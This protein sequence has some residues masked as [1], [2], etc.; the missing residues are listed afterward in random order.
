[1]VRVVG[2]MSGTSLDGVDAAILDTDGV[3]VAATGDTAYRP[4][5][6]KERAVLRTALGTWPGDPLAEA[7]A[8]VVEAAHLEVLDGLPAVDLVGFHGQTLS[9]DPAGARTH[10]AGDG[11]RLARASGLSVVWDF[12]SNDMALGGQG[13]P[14]APFYHWA[15][16]RAAGAGGPVGVLNLGGVRNITW[17]DPRAETPDA[18]E[19][20]LAFDTGPGNAAMDDLCAARG[21]G[22]FDDGGRLARRG[23]ADQARVKAALDHPYFFKMPPKSLDRDDFSGLSRTVADLPDADALATLAAVTVMSVKR[24]MQHAPRPVAE[25][26]VTGGGRRNGALM[27]GLRAALR[28]PVLPIED[29]GFDGDALEAQAFA[30]LAARVR[31]GLTTSA[32]GTTGIAAPVGGGRV[33]HP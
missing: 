16:A 9:H 8:R 31:A 1:M 22:A 29:R 24:G 18:P 11:A 20:L 15:C 23:A 3:T 13:A 2:M 30:Y 32:P 27:A 25:L 28:C 4:Y 14:L 33:S 21:L 19:A 6:D 26:W 10:Q 7:A 17:V 12:R 5:S